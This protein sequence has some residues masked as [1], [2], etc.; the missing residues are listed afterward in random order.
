MRSHRRGRS[1]GRA[2]AILTITL[3]MVSITSA[4]AETEE[5]T[6]GYDYTYLY[7]GG[8]Q[9]FVA[10]DGVR[11]IDVTAT[12]GNGGDKGSIQGGRPATVSGRMSVTPNQ[13]LFLVVG[14]DGGTGIG[15]AYQ[16]GFNGGGTGGMNSLASAYGAGGGGAT[17]IRTKSLF[18]EGTLESRIVVAAGGGGAGSTANGTGE[19]VRQGGAGGNAGSAGARA[20]SA[21]ANNTIGSGGFG[22]GAGSASAGGG[23]GSPAGFPYGGTGQTGEVGSD[24]ELGWGG[25]GGPGPFNAP[26]GGGGGG[27][28][29]LYGG[30][31]GAGGGSMTGGATFYATGGGGGGGGSSYFPGGTVQVASDPATPSI[32]IQFTVPGTEFTSGPPSLVSTTDVEFAFESTEEGSTFECSKDGETFMDCESPYTWE[33]VPEGENVLGV[34][35]VNEMGNYDPEPAEWSFRVD[36]TAPTVVIESGPE[37]E[38][39]DR[40]PEF[41]F[42]SDEPDVTFECRFDAAE[43]GPCSGATSDRPLSDLSFGPHVFEVKGTDGAGNSSSVAGRSFHVKSQDGPPVREPKLTL[44]KPV[45]NRKKGFAILPAMVDRAG[46]VALLGS[47]AVKPRRKETDRAATVRLKVSARGKAL[48]KLR[49]KGKVKVAV[50]IRF[51]SSEGR[52]V[53][54][55]KKLTLKLKKKP[56]KRR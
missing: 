43:F 36:R 46:I 3:G 23:G 5:E 10:P 45:F 48:R 14:Q 21:G 34:R 6:V 52:S 7:T 1:L 12:G 32:R 18:E 8:Q 25:S 33:D 26:P 56:R 40:R 9:F 39:S 2:A 42:G 20:E 19:G 54:K 31:G 55:P 35:A 4:T 22:G 53:S 51:T 38:T 28:G 37:G 44:K 15:A 41:T 13:E 47:K 17:D 49:R 11:A 50:K 30:G 24:G 29:G 27:G 16:G